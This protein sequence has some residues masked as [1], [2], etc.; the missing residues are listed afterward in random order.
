MDIDNIATTPRE[1]R[2]MAYTINL[3][4]GRKPP[5]ELRRN[6]IH[7]PESDRDFTTVAKLLFKDLMEPRP[8]DG[9]N[10][11]QLTPEGIA[12][13]RKVRG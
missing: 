10:Y 7:V 12:Y 1:L 6:Y 3:Q 4:G 13:M 5:K 9:P 2:L 11:F 8:Q